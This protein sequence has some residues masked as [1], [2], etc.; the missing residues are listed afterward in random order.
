[1]K[2]PEWETQ[3]S[4]DKV[5]EEIVVTE[6]GKTWEKGRAS[7]VAVPVLDS[8]LTYPIEATVEVVE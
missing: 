6:K 3:S 7:A 4:E 5:K 8:I 2:S 1:M